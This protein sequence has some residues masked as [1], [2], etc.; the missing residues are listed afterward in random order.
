MSKP[1]KP[2]KELVNAV[3]LI[4][5]RI[6]TDRN[7]CLSIFQSIQECAESSGLGFMDSVVCA[8][9]V[10]HR[11]YGY[12]INNM[13]RFRELVTNMSIRRKLDTSQEEATKTMSKGD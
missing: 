8:S 9:R 2:P 3:N 11:L 6:E 7:F 13:P 4:N 1:N 10:M 5:R 12:N